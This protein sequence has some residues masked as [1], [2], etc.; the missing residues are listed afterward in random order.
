MSGPTTIRDGDL[1]TKDPNDIRVF[2]FDWDAEHLAVG[3]TISTNSFTITALEPTTDTALTK[4]S[5]SI[6][7]GNRKTQLRLT[8]G[9]LGARYQIA[10]KIVTNE[11][12]AQTFERSFFLRVEEK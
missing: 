9:T 4:D 5:E 8:A 6:L 10:N 12:P 1:A 3:V 2:V 11:S 7:A